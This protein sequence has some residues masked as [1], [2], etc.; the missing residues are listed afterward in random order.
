MRQRKRAAKGRIIRVADLPER[1]GTLLHCPRCGEDSSA[2]R[3]DYFW[4]LLT[5]PFYCQNC[6]HAGARV[7]LRLVTKHTV[8]VDA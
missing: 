6:A 2:Y 3:S 8:Y 4:A 7:P 5:T 1:G